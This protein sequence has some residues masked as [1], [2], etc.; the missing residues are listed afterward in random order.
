MI[1]EA[2]GAALETAAPRVP[3][4]RT[5][6]WAPFPT[7]FYLVIYALAGVPLGRAVDRGSR[8]RLLA[9]GV[10]VWAGLT[11]LGGLAGSYAMLFATRLGVGI[12]EARLRSPAATSCD[13]GLV[14][15][16]TARVPW[17]PSRMAV[18]GGDH[19]QRCHQRRGR[20]GVCDGG[21]GAGAAGRRSCR[22][23]WSRPCCSSPVEPLRPSGTARRLRAMP[24]RFSSLLRIRALWWISFRARSPISGPV[25]L[26]LSSAAFSDAL[27]RPF[28]GA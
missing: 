2:L 6:N 12:G 27:S 8:K 5:L 16:A 28:G 26:L 13:Q 23:G 22:A 21:A 25:Q 9:A 20:A 15:P 17:P 10:A 18:P 3:P 24:L 1:G 14:L 19:A 4:S 11:A 7:Y